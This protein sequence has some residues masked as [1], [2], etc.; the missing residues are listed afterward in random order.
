[1]KYI[2][3]FEE[4]ND[5][6]KSITQS[7]ETKSKM[8]KDYKSFA[9]QLKSI[10][11]NNANE[12]PDALAKRILDKANVVNGSV[13]IPN[14][15]LLKY[16][17]ILKSERRASE[18]EKSIKDGQDKTNDLKSTTDKTL[19]SQNAAQLSQIQN[20]NKKLTDELT[21]LKSKV[22]KDYQDFDKYMKTEIET[23]KKELL[24]TNK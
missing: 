11:L 5:L 21:A 22:N 7:L 20:D 3:L 10:Y 8:V 1:M 14:A 13:K 24:N 12:D 18:I 19:A 2:A 6:D 17:Q 9:G 16:A 23:T 4:F 15:Y